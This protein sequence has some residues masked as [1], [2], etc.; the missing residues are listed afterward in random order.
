MGLF[1][2]PARPEFTPLSTILDTDFESYFD[3][4]FTQHNAL[5]LVVEKVYNALGGA[6]ATFPGTIGAA[7]TTLVSNGVSAAWQAIGS[8]AAQQAS[9]VAITGGTIA[10]I[11]DLAVADGGTGAS[12]AAT[13]RA[14]LGLVIGTN[15]QA[16]HALLAA[17]AG[18]TPT[19]GLF[20][21]GDGA[22]FVGESGATA[23]ASLG[24]GA[25]ATLATISNDIW[26]GAD[27]AIVNGGTGASDAGSARTNLGLGTLATKSSPLGI[28]DG[29]TAATTAAAAR[30]ALGIKHKFTI[31]LPV[32]GDLAV[33]TSVL[34]FDFPGVAMTITRVT[35]MLRTAPTGSS[36]IIDVTVAGTSIWDNGA[37]RLTI[38]AGQTVASQTTINN[39]AV[40]D[41]QK[42]QVDI[43]QVGSTVAGGFMLLKIEGEAGA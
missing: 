8:M 14:N 24:L 13:A 18:L 20:V 19:D 3:S 15:V 30:T 1:P 28:A 12:D 27:L 26:A 25:L 38:A 34:D 6:A 39:P 21:V 40:T 37:N 5:D 7:S 32:Q 42:I 29:G 23:R 41:N 31:I 10:G 17:I 4:L 9:A 33:G 43:D 2:F 16:F 11:T 22:T 36:A 35:A